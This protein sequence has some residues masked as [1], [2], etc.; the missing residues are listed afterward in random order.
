MY[1]ASVAYSTS[2]I[3]IQTNDSR[4][5]RVAYAYRGLGGFDCDVATGTPGSGNAGTGDCFYFNPFTSGYTSQAAGFEGVAGPGSSNTALNNPDF[6]AN[7]MTEFLGGKT[8][9]K[10]L[11]V[12]LV[13]SGE[14]DIDTGGGNVG[15]A[16]G[17]QYRRDD[18][19]DDLN[20]N[21][22]V[23]LEPCAFGLGAAGDTFTIPVTDLGGG[24]SIPAWTYTCEGN[25]AFHF[26]A[27]GLPQD[28]DQDVYAFFGELALPF[29][30]ALNVQV[31]VRYEDYGGDVGDTLDPKVAG[32]WDITE[33]I[34]LRGSITSSFRAPSLNQLSGV[35]TSLQFVGATSSFKAID[36]LG[37]SAISPEEAITTNFGVIFTPTDNWYISLDYWN[38]DFSEPILLENFGDVVDNCFP[39]SGFSAIQDL[40]CGKITFQDPSDPVESGIQ[41]VSVTYQN[42]PDV[43]TNGFDWVATWDIPTDNGIFTLG[44]QGTWINEYEVDSWIFADKFDAVG[45]LNRFESIARPLP[46]IKGNFSINW[47]Y[48]RHNVRFEAWYTADYDDK[49]AATGVDWDIDDHVTADIHYNFRF[50]NDNTRLFASI[51]NLTDEDPPLA[52]LDLNYD[53]YSHSPFGLMFKV[54][55]NHRFEAGPFQ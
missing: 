9:T 38:F 34:R 12:D 16:M 22:N 8:E 7:Y 19:E 25:G 50:N 42:G 14:T 26:L 54:G 31:A 48:E 27:A 18:I 55:V 49:S 21:S 17:A 23:G 44:T 47:A 2:E 46:E 24:N 13:F 5:D 15:W 1:T 3:D 37:N 11:V 53:P 40:A 6:M 36:T 51:Y 43:E 4:Q 45:D 30:D 52:R 41:R 28:D 32:T 35:G 20:S 33:T 10:L 39:A 29:S